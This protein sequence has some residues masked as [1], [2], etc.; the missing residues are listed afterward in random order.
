MIIEAFVPST[1][2]SNE[3]CIEELAYVSFPHNHYYHRSICAISKPIY[4]NRRRRNED[5]G[6]RDANW[7]FLELW[8]HF[9]ND[10]MLGSSSTARTEKNHLVRDPGCRESVPMPCIENTVSNDTLTKCDEELLWITWDFSRVVP[11][12]KRRNFIL[13]H[14]STTS[15]VSASVSIF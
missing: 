4:R 6:R 1:N 13:L 10:D 7:R 8:H 15:Y 11:F 5:L 9:W 12:V 2:H 14:T 3:T